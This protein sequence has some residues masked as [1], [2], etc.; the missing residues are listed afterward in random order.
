MSRRR[1][2]DGRNE[3]QAPPPAP[4]GVDSVGLAPLGG[5]VA[6]LMISFANMRS[7]DRVQ[8]N[9]DS[10][11]NQI[12]A[13]GTAAAPTVQAQAQPAAQPAQQPPPRR[14][15]PDPDRVYEIQ[16]ANAPSKGPA[17]APVVIAEFSD[18]Q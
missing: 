3:P 17:R 5:V 9:L 11:L 12:A 8:A 7:I 6:V 18:F 16:T 13:Q 10:R 15:G 4:R 2:D 14:S 1:R